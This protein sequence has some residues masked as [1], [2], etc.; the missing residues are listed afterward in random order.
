ML[1]EVLNSARPIKEQK[2][3]CERQREE[4]EKSD[5]RMLKLI[6]FPFS[7]S[8]SRK[9]KLSTRNCSNISVSLMNFFR[10]IPALGVGGDNFSLSVGWQIF[11]L[12]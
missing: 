8:I 12:N 9:D 5:D 2:E 1:R 4:R 11:L 7:I 6:I 3:I 10:S